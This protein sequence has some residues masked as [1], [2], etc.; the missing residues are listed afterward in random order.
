VPLALGIDIGSTN[1]KVVLVDVPDAADRA[2]RDVASLSAPT[3]HDARALVATVARLIRTVLTDST[4]PPLAVGIASMA[5]TGVPLSADGEPLTHLL[6]WDGHS[7][8]EDADALARV[9]GRQ[10]LFTAT[11]VR[12]SAKVPLATW[13]RLRRTEPDLYRR[14]THWSG[15]ADLVALALTGELVTDHTLAGRTM[16]YRLPGVGGALAGTFDPALLDVV[17]LLPGQLP[18]VVPADAVAGHVGLGS[19]PGWV[20]GD[21]V[22]GLADV[23]PQGTPVVVAGHDHAVGCWA[24]GTRAP[25]DRADSVGTA[26]AVLTIL[27]HAPDPVAVAAAGMSWVRPVAGGHDA[28]LAGTSSAGA[29]LDWLRGRLAVDSLDEHLAAARRSLDA[30]PEPT[31]V[32]VLPYLAGRQTP[33]PDAGARVVVEPDA[34]GVRLVRAVLEGISLQARWMA[35][36]QRDLAETTARAVGAPEG[37]E[38]ARTPR[39]SGALAVLGTAL[40]VPAWA[41]TKRRV[42]PE[43]LRWVDH[44]QPVATGAAV[45]ALVR[46]GALGDPVEQLIDAPTLGA[47][48]SA[49]PRGRPYERMYADFVAKALR[50]ASR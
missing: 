9:H 18:R 37:A 40:A 1:T 36:A 30:D 48:T 16:A 22:R 47:T 26:E 8:G 6:R 27:D 35:D 28:L 24:A 15:A 12:P 33:S 20:W 10:A 39:A 7:A 31:G 45:L 21:V 49:P 43:P 29:M 44:P 19:G 25:G 11:G 5:E 14:M 41:E 32:V 4:E 38:P 13:A 34:D 3:P 23:L 42:M 17:D 46:S 50:A 2:P